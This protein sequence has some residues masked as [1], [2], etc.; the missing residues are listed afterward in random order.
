MTEIE[1]KLVQ[2]EYREKLL[3][4]TKRQLNYFRVELDERETNVMKG[5]ED[6]LKEFVR[7]VETTC[8]HD[9][10][11]TSS[12]IIGQSLVKISPSM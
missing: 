1:E 6:E 3:A 4:K 9:L 7:S 11:L 8:Y 12:P 5:E 10:F 2:I